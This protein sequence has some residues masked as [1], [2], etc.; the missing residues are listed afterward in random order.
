M[1]RLNLIGIFLLLGMPF[2]SIAQN[3]PNGGFENWGLRVLYEEPDFWTTGNMLSFL[4]DETVALK[5]TDSYSGDYALRLETRIT[6]ETIPGYAFTNGQITEGNMNEGFQFTGGIPVSGA[7]AMLSGYFKYNIALMDVGLILVAFKKEGATI[8]QNIYPLLLNSSGYTRIDVPIDAM[9]ETPDS[10]FIAFA[11]TN[12]DNPRNGG[13][14]QIDSLWFTGIG[15]TI[16]NNNFEHWSNLE[17]YEPENWLTAN[18]FSTLFGGDTSATRTTD[19]W[20]GDYALRLESIYTLIPDDDGITEANMGYVMPWTEG[21]NLN[22]SLPAFP[23]DF[24]PYSLSGYYKF[25]PYDTDTALML[26]TLIDSEGNTYERTKIL[27][28]EDEYT[29]FELFLDYPYNA[30]ITEIGIIAN[31]SLFFDPTSTV[32]DLGE[33]GSILYLDELNLS[34]DCPVWGDFSIIVLEEPTCDNTT[35]LLDAGEGWGSYIWSNGDTSQTT[36]VLVEEPVTISVIVT[37]TDSWC[38]Y[39]DTVDLYPP[40]GCVALPRPIAENEKFLLFPN[41]GNGLFQLLIQDPDVSPGSLQVLS[42]SGSLLYDQDLSG[43]TED[44]IFEIDLNH[45]K[46]GI[47]LM[48]LNTEI[49]V[50]QKLLIIH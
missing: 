11:T 16:P 18:L 1:I 31:T 7:P 46:K 14:I 38:F 25:N 48:K 12:P 19:A 17:Y 27:P 34:S 10:A 22:E 20:S 47:Y 15:D 3:I 40:D 49:T 13:W 9:A 4:F 45:L 28:A 21:V 32:Q 41:P 35:A 8:G 50:Y 37:A 33:E 39:T 24:N 36:S 29:Y 26:V 23:I 42:A 30:E 5:T 2:V 44:R 43:K 6:D